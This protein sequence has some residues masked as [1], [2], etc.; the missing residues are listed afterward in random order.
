[1]GQML[2]VRDLTD[3]AVHATLTR[4]SV[5]KA[6]KEGVKDPAGKLVMKSYSD[7]LSEAEIN[8]VADYTLTLK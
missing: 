5:I 3:P 1:M 2:K 4:E 7:K 8:A 6:V